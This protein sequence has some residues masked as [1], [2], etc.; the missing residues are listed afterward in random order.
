[1]GWFVKRETRTD[2]ES[3]EIALAAG[4]VRTAPGLTALFRDLAPGEPR[5]LLDL[6]PALGDNLRFYSR[7]TG[8]IRFADLL[9]RGMPEATPV[10]PLHG[11]RDH[12]EFPYD[13][14]LAWNLLD[15]VTPERRRA[16]VE[17]LADLAT[18]GSR[19]HLLL[20]MS[21][22]PFLRPLRFTIVDRERLTFTAV[23][24]PRPA[25]PRPLPAQVDPLLRPF[26]VV[27]A[28]VLRD[29]MREYVAVR[30]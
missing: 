3:R 21:D 13:L 17:E 4:V 8:R 6:G 26:R 27:R 14:V 24:P 23:G 5:A 1:M 20:D 10:A 28:F 12:P 9:V 16:V 30:A 25:L 15:Q 19:L 18:P 29:G 7:Y 2:V 22:E 11:L